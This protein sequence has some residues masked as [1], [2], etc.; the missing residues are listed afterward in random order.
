MEF[1]CANKVPFF[2]YMWNMFGAKEAHRLFRINLINQLIKISLFWT[3]CYIILFWKKK[4]K[5][6]PIESVL[7]TWYFLHKAIKI[8]G[9][10]DNILPHDVVSVFIV[11][12]TNIK[13]NYK[14]DNLFFRFKN[15]QPS[16]DT[17]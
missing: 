5:K 9:Q 15:H 17:S 4:K 6:Y 16:H 13:L 7:K 8:F 10:H 1:L 14:T 11:K 2:S 12:I 3:K